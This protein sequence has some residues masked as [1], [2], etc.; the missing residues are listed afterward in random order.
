MDPNSDLG[1]FAYELQN[2]LGTISLSEEELG[3]PGLACKAHNKQNA[4]CGTIDDTTNDGTLL[5]D[6]ICARLSGTLATA[7]DGVNA[8]FHRRAAAKSRR[9]S[10]SYILPK[11][12]QELRWP[13]TH[14][15]LEQIWGDE[16][17]V[18]RLNDFVSSYDRRDGRETVASLSPR[19]NREQPP[20][21]TSTYFD[22]VT[23]KNIPFV[24]GMDVAVAPTCY[25]PTTNEPQ[26]TMANTKPQEPT[27]S[28]AE[29][30][31][32][33][34]C[35]PVT[36]MP[37]ECSP[38]QA[39]TL[40]Q[41]QSSN[42][43]S[44][45]DRGTDCT[46]RNN[47]E[48]QLPEE[49]VGS[50][51][52]VTLQCH[53][54][55]GKTIISLGVSFCDEKK[56]NDTQSKLQEF[57]RKDRS[58]S[59]LDP[60][61]LESTVDK[62]DLLSNSQ[63]FAALPGISILDISS[64]LQ[65]YSKI[66]PPTNTIGFDP[67]VDSVDSTAPSP[68]VED[69]G[70]LQDRSNADIS[71][72][73]KEPAKDD[74]RLSGIL[75][76]TPKNPSETSPVFEDS[77]TRNLQPNPSD[78]WDGEIE[79]I[80]HSSASIRRQRSSFKKYASEA[81]ERSLYSSGTS[82]DHTSCETSGRVKHLDLG[83][84]LSCPAE[85]ER[86]V[87][88][89]RLQ[90]DVDKAVDAAK[91]NEDSLPLVDEARACASDS[92][93]DDI[94]ELEHIE[95]VHVEESFDQGDFF[96]S[97]ETN[98]I[99]FAA[100]QTGAI[101]N[102]LKGEGDETNHEDKTDNLDDTSS[103]DKSR[104]SKSLSEPCVE[105]ISE[106]SSVNVDEYH[107][108]FLGV[109]PGKI[110][111]FSKKAE[112]FTA[113]E[114]NIESADQKGYFASATASLA[115]KAQSTKTDAEF[116][117]CYSEGARLQNAVRAET[118]LLTNQ[119]ALSLVPAN[120]SASS[121][122]FFK[123]TIN[124]FGGESGANDLAA[125]TRAFSKM[126]DVSSGISDKE[127]SCKSPFEF[128]RESNIKSKTD[129]RWC[130]PF[131]D[132][133][134]D[135]FTKELSRLATS[136][137]LLREELESFQRKLSRA[138]ETR[139]IIDLSM[140][141][142]SY[143][144]TFSVNGDKHRW[145]WKSNTLKY[146]TITDPL[147]HEDCCS[148]RYITSS[149]GLAS[150]L[151]RKTQFGNQDRRLAYHSC[152][153]QFD[154]GTQRAPLTAIPRNED[155]PYRR[156]CIQQP[157]RSVNY[158]S[159]S[160]ERVD[161]KINLLR[162]RLDQK[163]SALR[164]AIDSQRISVQTDHIE[165]EDTSSFGYA[166]SNIMRTRLESDQSVE[167]ISERSENDPLE[168]TLGYCAGNALNINGPS[169]TSFIKST[170]LAIDHQ[171]N[172]SSNL[173]SLSAKQPKSDNQFSQV[174]NCRNRPESGDYLTRTY[175]FDE[176]DS[177]EFPQI[178]VA[179]S[180]NSLEFTTD[181]GLTFKGIEMSS[182]NSG[183]NSNALMDVCFV[184]SEA[185]TGI[186]PIQNENELVTH[187]EESKLSES[188]SSGYITLSDDSSSFR[189]SESDGSRQLSRHST[190]PGVT[191]SYSTTSSLS[192]Q[193]HLPVFARQENSIGSLSSR[194]SLTTIDSS[195]AEQMLV[196]YRE[197]QQCMDPHSVSHFPAR[198][199]PSQN[200][201]AASRLRLVRFDLPLLSEPQIPYYISSDVD[202]IDAYVPGSS[203]VFTDPF[204][205][206]LSTGQSTHASKADPP[207]CL[208]KDPDE[209]LKDEAKFKPRFA[210]NNSHT[211][212]NGCPSDAGQI[213]KK[214][215]AVHKKKVPLKRSQQVS[216]CQAPREIRISVPSKNTYLD[217]LKL[218]RDLRKSI[219]LGHKKKSQ[220]L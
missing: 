27:V 155:P 139:T 160:D 135:S 144:S 118:K 209:Y 189:F 205:S 10:S 211:T 9:P 28:S 89:L 44:K 117:G 127:T 80:E 70:T 183:V 83:H 30:T 208:E 198:H 2:S 63:E 123:P 25:I 24:Q 110:P 57:S 168:R 184:K 41:T 19:S 119:S 84:L 200:T 187:G 204:L 171:E 8:C 56:D 145:D 21:G 23:I 49:L 82:K 11:Y 20:Q 14:S 34:P 31:C 67:R 61:T 212:K 74:W 35:A 177:L 159:A 138:S 179:L 26:P 86:P 206:S 201:S 88:Q 12:S 210:L 64:P 115:S 146:G 180:P 125:L 150:S 17:H 106:S 103:A 193:E 164:T 176:D 71:C 69:T 76:S 100:S 152:Q 174:N 98:G 114:G 46:G 195:K 47:I 38:H 190:P 147:P 79:F 196:S 161:A 7:I 91:V 109:I 182:F 108:T 33:T 216:S 42:T 213:E 219:L 157:P 121:V 133:D 120:P 3:V 6:E 29:T 55:E 87:D 163:R 191:A 54:N 217:K 43:P 131:C 97:G 167:E 136:E 58:T 166:G 128:N 22:Y 78:F 13:M 218:S 93:G 137:R 192:F 32:S 186:S 68:S 62:T 203:D 52:E 59:T 112:I 143:G 39:S 50:G 153:T 75:V 126:P 95:I 170:S 113:D 102:D 169:P 40:V 165:E 154:S 156:Q 172:T 151:N 72:D 214:R 48:I 130:G 36:N 4:I 15:Q 96:Q 105:D 158:A 1:M 148:S 73:L 181:D 81:R 37:V 185:E 149:T 175:N 90:Q 45:S 111:T 140:I 129:D 215:E 178:E 122:L 173:S 16:I 197:S 77:R 141:D 220:L 18:L 134:D 65:Q 53:D 124:V 188:K 202:D 66:D 5:G 85:V 94:Q 142:D 60:E 92:T 107:A 194:L 101:G 116:I 207:G 199:A 51:E 104:S 162:S 99:I 132:N